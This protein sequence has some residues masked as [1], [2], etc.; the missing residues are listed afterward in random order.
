MSACFLLV[1]PPYKKPTP[2]GV[3]IMT[4][5]AAAYMKVVSPV[6]MHGAMLPPNVPL[7]GGV[8]A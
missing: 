2:P 8:I 7:P 4:N 1:K 6:S 5:D 3:I